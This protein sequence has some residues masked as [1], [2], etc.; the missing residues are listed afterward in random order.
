MRVM[1]SL[2]EKIKLMID[3]KDIEA[4]IGI[5]ISELQLLKTKAE[6]TGKKLHEIIKPIEAQYWEGIER[7][8]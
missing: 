6:Y 1:A 2:E 7:S 8:R 3:L 5:L 4:E